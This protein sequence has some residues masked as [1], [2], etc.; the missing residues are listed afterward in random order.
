MRQNACFASKE[1]KIDC[2]DEV[3]NW[4]SSEL[5]SQVGD[6]DLKVLNSLEKSKRVASTWKSKQKHLKC[7]SLQK[8]LS[9][10]EFCGPKICY[11]LFARSNLKRNL[12]LFE[13]GQIQEK[14]SLL[15]LCLEESIKN[16]FDHV[17]LHSIDTLSSG[18][19][20]EIPP[21]RG[22]QWLR[23]SIVIGWN[24]NHL[25]IDQTNKNPDLNYS[26]DDKYFKVVVSKY[27]FEK[28]INWFHIVGLENNET[29][30][31]WNSQIL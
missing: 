18:W 20:W 17:C 30:W 29:F 14:C 9:V 22:W 28:Q 16:T 23:N 26:E 10:Q 12:F 5:A 1:V 11:L 13:S 7:W 21:N 24:A 15:Y 3:K 25:L 6:Y 27:L 4:N 8:F 2:L 31:R 19:A